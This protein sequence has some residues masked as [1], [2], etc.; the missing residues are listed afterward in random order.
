MN[1]TGSKAQENIKLLKSTLKRY[2]KTIQNKP[3]NKK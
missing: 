2:L 3:E 1:Y